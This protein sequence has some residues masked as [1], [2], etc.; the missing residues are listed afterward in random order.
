M[1]T[2]QIAIAD[3]AYAGAFRD[4]L[5]RDAR[6]RP[7]LVEHPDT[8]TEGVIVVDTGTLEALPSKLPNPE[9]VVLITRN[10]P[11][12]LA[13]AWEA[14]IVSVVFEDDPLDTAFL[15]IMGARL[16][17]DKAARQDVADSTPAASSGARSRGPEG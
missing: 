17:A 6:W 14:G 9:R 1:Q 4:L 11:A 3:G 12:I 5:I 15:A 2:I 10:E 8:R 13:R 16:K 7:L